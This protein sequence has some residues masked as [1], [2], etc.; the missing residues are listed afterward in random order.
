MCSARLRWSATCFA[1]VCFSPSR[2]AT[3]R[4]TASRLWYGS[5]LPRLQ[6]PRS[7]SSP[8][9][10]CAGAVLRRRRPL[11]CCL[12]ILRSPDTVSKTA[13]WHATKPFSW[14][15][16]ETA[17]GRTACPL[18]DADRLAAPMARTSHGW[19]SNWRQLACSPLRV[20]FFSISFLRLHLCC[21]PRAG[22]MLRNDLLTSRRLARSRMCSSRARCDH[23]AGMARA[24]LASSLR[25]VRAAKHVCF[26]A[27]GFA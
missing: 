6:L 14:A 26:G 16:L 15:W 27:A 4:R 8:S 24:Y 3:P 7:V 18:P 13:A 23:C 2:V 20:F 12:S 21:R 9:P 10:L 19:P 22:R 25:M 17:C 1:A 5:S 11:W